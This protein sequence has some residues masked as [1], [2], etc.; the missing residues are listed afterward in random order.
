MSDNI[1]NQVVSISQSLCRRPETSWVP[2]KREAN[3]DVYGVLRILYKAFKVSALGVECEGGGG[4]GAI[5]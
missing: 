3:E 2:N 5:A 1:C 4:I